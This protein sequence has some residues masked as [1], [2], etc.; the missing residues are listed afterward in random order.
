MLAT[1]SQAVSEW[2]W[3]VGR[4]RLGDAWLLSDYD[5]WERNPHYT[6]PDVPHPESDEPWSSEAIAWQ[7]HAARI[8][9]DERPVDYWA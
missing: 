4:E 8:L 3:N 7:E 9:C 5:T 6:G 1:R 2:A